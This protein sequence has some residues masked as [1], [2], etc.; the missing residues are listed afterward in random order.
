[1]N[2]KYNKFKSYHKH[3]EDKRELDQLE[4]TEQIKTKHFINLILNNLFF[5]I[6]QI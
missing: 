5:F 2:L 6:T 1:M 3:K 4:N